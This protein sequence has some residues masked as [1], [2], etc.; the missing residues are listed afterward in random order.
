MFSKVTSHLPFFRKLGKAVTAEETAPPRAEIRAPSHARV[1]LGA[2]LRARPG[3]V[4]VYSADPSTL[5][6]L[7]QCLFA[8]LSRVHCL[9]P[10]SW[11]R[12]CSGRVDVD[13]RAHLG[14]LE[15]GSWQ[16]HC[17]ES[18]QAAQSAG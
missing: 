10:M 16:A 14:A 9:M 13:I 15:D 1:H 7:T 8:A 6:S 17:V 4:F 18:G 12:P 5:S 11:C 3:R 2:C